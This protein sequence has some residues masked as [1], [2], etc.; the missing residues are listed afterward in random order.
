MCLSTLP[1]AVNLRRCARPELVQDISVAAQQLLK[2]RDSSP[3]CRLSVGVQAVFQ[4]Q[5]IRTGPPARG[6][7]VH[8]HESFSVRGVRPI[9]YA[10]SS[11]GSIDGSPR[12]LPRSLFPLLVHFGNAQLARM[13]DPCDSSI[14]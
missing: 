5:A 7:G 9:R 3:G 12:P 4:G 1:T 11:S 2:A 14:P 13:G 8:T 10:S 6:Q